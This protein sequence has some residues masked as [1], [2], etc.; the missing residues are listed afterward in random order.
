MPFSLNTKLMDCRSLPEFFANWNPGSSDL[1]ITN[2]YILTPHL[3]GKK[4]PCDTLYQ[5]QFG[6]G[7]PNDEMADKMLAV[8]EGKSYERIIAIGGGTVID[9]AKLFVFGSGLRC[10]QIFAEGGQL[11]RKRRLVVIP[12]TCG[13]GSEVTMISIVYFKQKATK[14]GLAVPALFPDEAV[15]IPGLLRS[16]PYEVFASSSIDALIHSVESFVSPKATPFSKAMARDSIGRILREYK[17]LAAGGAQ[18]LPGEDSIYS[19]LV[20]SVMG[21]IAFGNAGVGAVHALSYPIGGIYH[22]P[23]GKANYMMF[24]AVF[25]AYKKLGANLTELEEALSTALECGHSEVWDKLFSLIEFILPNQ[26]VSALGVDKE[27]CREMAASVIKNQQRLLVNNPIALD[28]K[29]IAEIYIE[30]L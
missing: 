11:Q 5:E 26:P 3:N 15:L 10:A 2:E 22:V 27:K 28:E 7:E 4:V 9:I 6:S 17:T 13:T 24:R 20:A 16:L 14:M 12:T 8:I 23:H 21:G 30:C 19:V 18:V 1:I 25:S 29:Q